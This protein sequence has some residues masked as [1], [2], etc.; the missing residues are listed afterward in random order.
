MTRLASWLAL[1]IGIALPCAAEAQTGPDQAR[2]RALFM[3]GGA[4]ADAEEWEPALEAFEG[5]L[6]LVERASTMVA[7]A[8][9]LVRLE[10]GRD[11]LAMLDRLRESADPRRD[12]AHLRAGEELRP[13]AEEIAAQEALAAPTEPRPVVLPDVDVEPEPPS[14]H[15]SERDLLGELLYPIIVAGAG[16]VALVA[17][18][19]FIG[20][21]E[22]AIA[23]R[24]ALC[25]DAV[26]PD[27]AARDAANAHHADA[28]TWTVATN[29]AW[30][31]GAVL[32]TAGAVWGALVLALGG[33][34]EETVVV[35]A[36]GPSYAGAHLQ[37][38]F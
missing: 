12:A 11:A 24:D 1:T 5:S 38:T 15:P 28:D 17:M 3:E 36:L 29:V 8:G 34:S 16:V 14:S 21:R 32:L 18:G 2:A 27:I 20:L 26:C 37:G 23:E 6:A 7:I 4:Y 35:P 33:S 13:R 19:V 10:R 22:G 30:V 31:S 25:P 9:V